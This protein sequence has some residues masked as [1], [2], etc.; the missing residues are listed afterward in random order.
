[1]KRAFLS[2]PGPMAVKVILAVIVVA[3]GLVALFFVYDWMGNTLLDS[4]G[5]IS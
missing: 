3:V 4:G 2:L 5:T 1:M